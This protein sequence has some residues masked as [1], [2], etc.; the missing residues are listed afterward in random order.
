MDSSIFIFICFIKGT[1]FIKSSCCILMYFDVFGCYMLLCYDT[2]V[3]LSSS[4][5][6]PLRIGK[7]VVLQ[8]GEGEPIKAAVVLT[9]YPLVKKPR[10]C[11]Q[12]IPLD[13][14]KSFR[15]TI[16]QQKDHEMAGTMAVTNFTW[17]YLPHQVIG[18][19]DVNLDA[20]RLVDGSVELTSDSVR[21]LEALQQENAVV[22]ADG[23]PKGKSSKKTKQKRSM[24]E[25]KRR[26]AKMANKKLKPAVKG[27]NAEED[28]VVVA[29]DIRRSAK[30]RKIISNLLIKAAGLDYVK[31]GNKAAFHAET[32]LCR[33]KI[34]SSKVHLKELASAGPEYFQGKYFKA[35]NGDVFGKRV[36][37]DLDAVLKDLEGNES[38]GKPPSQQSWEALIR[39]IISSNVGGAIQNS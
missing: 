30:G 12:E 7:V 9:L 31:F 6:N 11:V 15:A 39:D 29:S 34:G 20:S 3:L 5:L 23:V 38:K 1:H 4:Y 33:L 27:L 18:I 19:L 24:A 22:E 14:V 2:F 16:L 36:F 10:P 37:E 25:I 35:R 8:F 26:L 13:R 32:Q 21:A 28:S 17:R